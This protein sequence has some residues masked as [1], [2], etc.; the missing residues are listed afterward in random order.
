MR[1]RKLK[2]LVSATHSYG[3]EMV[4]SCQGWVVTQVGFFSLYLQCNPI[5]LHQ[6]VFTGHLLDARP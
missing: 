6:Q 5:E 1:V 2:A 4:P 3:E